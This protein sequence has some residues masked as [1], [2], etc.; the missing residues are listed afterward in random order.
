MIFEVP[1]ELRPYIIQMHDNGVITFCGL[2]DMWKSEAEELQKEWAEGCKAV[3]VQTMNQTINVQGGYWDKMFDA[4]KQGFT[5]SNTSS[6]SA[7]AVHHDGITTT[8]D[9]IFE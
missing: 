5:C 6:Y 9:K 8:T 2:P 4:M 3:N 1:R 7:G